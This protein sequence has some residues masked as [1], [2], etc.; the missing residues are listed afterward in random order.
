[1]KIM[2]DPLRLFYV[3]G[4]SQENANLVDEATERAAFLL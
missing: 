4:G 1:M 3:F 2:R